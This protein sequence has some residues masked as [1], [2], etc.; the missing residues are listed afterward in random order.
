MMEN[1][2]IGIKILNKVYELS[3]LRSNESMISA[4]EKE[5]TKELGFCKVSIMG[6]LLYF[7]SKGYIKKVSRINK[8]MIRLK[9]IE[10]VQRERAKKT[11]I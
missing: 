10:I 8:Y 1:D 5:I 9:G 7:E 11:A 6:Y 2:S 3:M 4:I